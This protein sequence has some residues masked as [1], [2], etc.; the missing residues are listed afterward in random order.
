MSHVDERAGMDRCEGGY[1]SPDSPAFM[2]GRLA[3]ALAPR[4]PP[5]KQ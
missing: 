5:C 1:K 2:V 4:A 3:V